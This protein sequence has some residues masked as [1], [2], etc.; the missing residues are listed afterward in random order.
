MDME[1]IIQVRGK[2]ILRFCRFTAGERDCGDEL[3]QDTMLYLMEHTGLIQTEKPV[4]GL[5]MSIAVFL[6]KSKKRKYARRMKLVTTESLDALA[7]ENTEP[8]D[9]GETTEE[10][11]IR[12]AE[13]ERMRAHLVKLPEKYKWPLLMYYLSGMD[14]REIGRTLKLP[15]PTVKTRIRRAK[16]M[17]RKEMDEHER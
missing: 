14:V 10:L 1:E 8:A 5:V 13:I 9:P 15:P 2:D 12:R 11:A 4:K 6:W 16:E 17:L 7:E 3:Y